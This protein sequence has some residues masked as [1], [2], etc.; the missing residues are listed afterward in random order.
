MSPHSYAFQV[1]VFDCTIIGD[2]SQEMGLEGAKRLFGQV[3]SDD[4]ERAITQSHSPLGLSI[5]ILV[6]RTPNRLMLVDTSMGGDDK[7][8]PD[9]LR[10]AGIEPGDVDDVIITHG[11]HDHIGGLVRRDGAPTFPKA[12]YFMWRTE[13]DYWL[14]EAE[15]TNSPNGLINRTLIPIRDHITLLDQ[16]G[17][18]APGISVIH[19]PGHTPGHMALLLTSGEQSLLHLVDSAHHPMQIANP[20]WSPAFDK[21]PDLSAVTRRALFERAASEN[22]LTMAYHFAF[23][24]LGRI[25]Q[26]GNTFGWDA[27]SPDAP[28]ELR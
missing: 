12:R 14:G 7:T 20:G 25:R 1:G 4:L 13:W 10:Q 21:Q 26:Q 27:I 2:K 23:P 3:A 19:A 15:K 18:I 6:I 16:E 17:E 9:H 24:A 28:A 22:G 8:L 5:N 11:H